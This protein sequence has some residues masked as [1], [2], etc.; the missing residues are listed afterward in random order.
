MVTRM[1]FCVTLFFID[2]N[3]DNLFSYS[4]LGAALSLINYNK[5]LLKLQGR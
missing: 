1:G 4:V 3:Y 2:Y 5:Q